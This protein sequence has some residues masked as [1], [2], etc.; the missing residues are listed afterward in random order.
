MRL[1]PLVV[2]A[3]PCLT[4]VTPPPPQFL[5][6]MKIMDYSLL[7]GIHYKS[8]SREKGLR[9]RSVQLSPDAKWVSHA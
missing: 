5:E 4:L 9:R 8:R 6:R 7:V 2:A 1:L 3:T